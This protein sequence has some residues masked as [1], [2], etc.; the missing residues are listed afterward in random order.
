[1]TYWK[2]IAQENWR[3]LPLG[4]LPT[5][6]K[7]PIPWVGGNQP[8]MTT[9]VIDIGAPRHA[10]NCGG[11]PV[12][13]QDCGARAF[14]TAQ[15][16]WLYLAPYENQTVRLRSWAY[17]PQAFTVEQGAG[18]YFQ[19]F[20]EVKSNFRVNAEVQIGLETVNGQAYHWL[21]GVSGFQDDAKRAVPLDW[22]TDVEY[23]LQVH[24]SRFSDGWALF[25]YKA[26]ELYVTGPNM[27]PDTGECA[28]AHLAYTNAVKSGRVDV[29]YRSTVLELAA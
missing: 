17:Y 18:T 23:E 14:L 25:K 16:R 5:T 12:F 6:Y 4:D 9:Q 27:H 2:P 26:L 10:L 19:T 24:L 21:R 8:S 3:E 29:Q 11:V 13:G 15:G 7:A 22:Q 20:A 1:M 28:F